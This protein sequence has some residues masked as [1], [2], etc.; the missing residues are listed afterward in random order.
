VVRTG[1]AAASLRSPRRFLRLRVARS[2][3][4]SHLTFQCDASACSCRAPVPAND[5]FVLQNKGHV[6]R[7]MEAALWAFN[8]ASSFEEGC[9]LVGAMPCIG[10]L[11]LTFMCA[12]SEFGR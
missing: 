12:C 2:A 4:R 10:W 6:V 1:A 7:S 3:T 9:L 8:K 11:L 5:C